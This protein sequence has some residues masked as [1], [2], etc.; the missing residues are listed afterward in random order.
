MCGEGRWKRGGV[1]FVKENKMCCYFA[2]NKELPLFCHICL[3]YIHLSRGFSHLILSCA[4]Y[5]PGVA[6]DP[7]IAERSRK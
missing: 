1:V 2:K 4:V 5:D 6:D 7:K 3:R